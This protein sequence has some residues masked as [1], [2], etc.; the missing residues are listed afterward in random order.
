M[1]FPVT[2]LTA[3]AGILVAVGLRRKRG[4]GRDSFF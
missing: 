2:F 4:G 3:A 1:E